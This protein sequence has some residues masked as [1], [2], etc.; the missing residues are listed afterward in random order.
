MSPEELSKKVRVSS[1]GDFPSHTV[2]VCTKLRLQ[3]VA[4]G[5]E[6][7]TVSIM[8]YETEIDGKA[9]SC[10]LFLPDRYIAN[11]KGKLHVIKLCREEKENKSGRTNYNL[12]VI[13][14]NR[15]QQLLSKKE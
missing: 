7:R 12:R 2:F 14:A 4:A 15:A 3:A 10:E 1:F 9:T 8:A 13:D 11:I 6:E 5:G